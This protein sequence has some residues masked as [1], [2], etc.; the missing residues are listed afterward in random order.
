[1]LARMR[2]CLNHSGMGRS[3]VLL[4][5]DAPL[6]WPEELGRSLLQHRAGDPIESEPNRLFKRKTDAE[7]FRRLHKRPLEVGANLIARTAHAALGLLNNVRRLTG[8]DIPLAWDPTNLGRI[9]AIEVYPAATL[10]ARGFK[11]GPD[12]LALFGSEIC[13]PE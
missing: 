13:L 5:L 3:S 12:C 8:H 10:L 1:M 11:N 2:T 7:I 4:A 6:G 9:A